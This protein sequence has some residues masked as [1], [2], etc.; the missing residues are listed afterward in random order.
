MVIET[1]PCKECD[2]TPSVCGCDLELCMRDRKY[3]ADYGSENNPLLLEDDGL[4]KFA[5]M[6]KQIDE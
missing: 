1:E 5:R 2:F 3:R 4:A 6:Q